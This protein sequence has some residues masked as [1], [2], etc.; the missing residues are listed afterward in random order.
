L[1][2]SVKWVVSGPNL[3]AM[4]KVLCWCPDDE[5][6]DMI[7]ETEFSTI[8]AAANS[9]AED[10][11]AILQ[12][13]VDSTGNAYF[14][15][16]GGRTP[17]FVFRH[18]RKMQLDWSNIFIT[19]TD[20]RWVPVRDQ[21]SNERLVRAQL[22]QGA[23]SAATFVPFYGGEST[24]EAGVAACDAR[25]AAVGKPLDAV[26]LGMGGDGHFASLFPGDPAVDVR[27]ELC[28]AVAEKSY[29]VGR[30]SLTATSILAAKKLILLYA[31]PVKHA[32]YE[33]AKKPGSY[34]DLPLRLIL[35][36]VQT[37]VEVLSAP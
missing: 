20:E 22:L 21:H 29:R 13:A 18:L 17:R 32:V 9:L 16:S 3:F 2:V 37:P 12:K 28:A 24:P 8:E 7:R 6:L 4:P 36:Q 14:A 10:L 23:A 26:Y 35:Q 15:V 34:H 1:L 30:M 11:T 25:L 31:G 5:Q 27:N 33:E 19:V